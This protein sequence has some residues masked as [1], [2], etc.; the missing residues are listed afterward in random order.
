MGSWVSDPSP[1]VEDG[2]GRRGKVGLCADLWIWWMRNWIFITEKWAQ[3]TGFFEI[4]WVVL[5][6]CGVPWDHGWVNLPQ[7]F[8]MQWADVEKL[9]LMRILRI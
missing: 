1:G 3:E 4:F 9:V 6:S 7:G 8:R 5:G 2:V